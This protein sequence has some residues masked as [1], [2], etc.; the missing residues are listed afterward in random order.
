MKQR[1]VTCLLFLVL[2]VAGIESLNAQQNNEKINKLL[3]TGG[4]V[5]AGW[6]GDR[7]A[8]QTH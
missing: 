2:C 1:T 8:Q 7:T 5:S 6:N 3:L 4:L